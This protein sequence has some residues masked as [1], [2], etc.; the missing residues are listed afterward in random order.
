MQYTDKEIKET[1]D[2]HAKWLSKKSGGIRAY[3]S[4]ADLSG[5]NLSKTIFEGIN[6]LAYLGIVPDNKGMARAYKVTTSIGEGV[7]NGGVNYLE[8]KEYSANLNKDITQQ[9]ASGINLAT[10]AW[11]LNEKQPDRR[12]FLMKFK[13]TPDNVCVPIG[14][15]GKFRVAKCYKVG[16]CDWQGNLKE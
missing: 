3:L 15:D 1:L 4:E 12:L 16:E 10:F 14:S 6:W 7:Y 2:K 5:A 8:H 11:C 13:V 9:C